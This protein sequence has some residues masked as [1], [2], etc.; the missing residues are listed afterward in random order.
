MIIQKTN[1]KK[2]Y[3][4]IGAIAVIFILIAYLLYTSFYSGKGEPTDIVIDSENMNVIIVQKYKS[5]KQINLELFENEN[6]LDFKESK[7]VYHPE[8]E[9]GNVNPFK[10]K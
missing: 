6:Y 3:I 4:N 5:L 1:K 7:K 9:K 10:K 8:V 2:L